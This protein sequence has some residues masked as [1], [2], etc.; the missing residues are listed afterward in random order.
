M[1][2]F[3][4]PLLIILLFSVGACALSIINTHQ[5]LWNLQRLEIYYVEIID[6]R[7]GDRYFTSAVVSGNQV[8]HSESS[9]RRSSDSVFTIEQLFAIAN[10]NC[11]S[12]QINCDIDY[13]DEYHYISELAIF[14]WRVLRV[15]VF[16]VCQSIQNCPS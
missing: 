10:D 11:D 1:S 13:D 5:H 15:E 9:R 7:H 12:L 3:R 16:E 2:K 14:D 4:I 8:I 6:V